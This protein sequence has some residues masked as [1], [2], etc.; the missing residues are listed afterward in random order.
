[1]AGIFISYRREDSAADAGRLLETLQVCCKSEVYLDLN[2]PAGSDF[3][4]VLSRK[5]ETCDVVLVLIGPRWL[6][7]Q[8]QLTGGRRLDAKDDYVRF[9]VVTALKAGKTIIPV[10]LPGGKLP[11]AGELPEDIRDIVW[12]NAVDIRYEHW[13]ADVNALMAG[14]PASVG[15]EE[16]RRSRLSA[17]RWLGLLLVPILVIS[18]VQVFAVRQIEQVSPEV[19]YVGLSV[20]FG[21]LHAFQGKYDSW[22][23]IALGSGIS[24]GA[25]VLICILVPVISGNAI[26]PT[27]LVPVRLFGIL[28]AGIFAGYL[29][30]A[31]GAGAWLRSRG[32]RDFPGP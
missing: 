29:V 27:S 21:V 16:P 26:I 14:L 17:A 12:R 22:V 25:G 31:L 32:S 15:C 11:G 10:L 3:R 13:A 9:E 18:A 8:D 30:G 20:A 7:A 19:L 1:M 28:V 24:F 4:S 2:T 5:L 6:S 23:F